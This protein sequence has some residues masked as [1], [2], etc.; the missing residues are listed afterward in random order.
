MRHE[1]RL[2]PVELLRRVT[3]SLEQLAVQGLASGAVR[4]ASEGLQAEL[5]ALD[6]QLRALI[7][8]GV[9]LLARLVQDAAERPPGA[10]TRSMAESAVAGAV[11]EL[12]RSMPGV[13]ALSRELIERMNA[14]LERSSEAAALRNREL[15]EPGARAREMATGVVE[16]VV[17]ELEH[18][19]PAVSPMGAE[20][21]SQAGRGF[22]QGLGEALESRSEKFDEVLDEA[23]RR[24]VH[25]VVEQ[26]DLE[27]RALRSRSQRDMG[28]AV[29]SMAERTAVATVRG[30]SE[31]LRRQFRATRD[32]GGPPL[33][34]A[35]RE[36]TLGVLS[37][38]SERLR[39][40]LA[41]MTGVG[42]VLALTAF[43]LA[44][45]R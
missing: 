7:E 19:L 36:V 14:W 27:L 15:R 8:D 23:G 17:K 6:G 12:R 29:A 40:P 25:A 31:E 2:S 28:S 22:I 41:V 35:S 9:A 42:G 30:A 45:R 18:A 26:L 16:G 32:A 20:V 34:V 37:A 3:L 39:R 33:R 5:P 24:L 4:G 13:D 10:W 43:T 44:R 21:A 38:L 11:D 1:G